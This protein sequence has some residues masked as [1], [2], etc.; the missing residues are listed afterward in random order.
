MPIPDNSKI[1][2]ND[3]KNF[4]FPPKPKEWIPKISFFSMDLEKN[5]AEY[6]PLELQG[7]KNILQ[8]KISN[9]YFFL[10]D[11]FG[12]NGVDHKGLIIPLFLDRE[13]RNGTFCSGNCPDPIPEE[14]QAIFIHNDFLKKGIIS[15]ELGHS[16][17]NSLSLIG[18]IRKNSVP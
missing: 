5:S 8:T 1:I 13:D 12:L 16:I 11:N 4:S 18:K 3:Y 14:L 6:F 2:L 7:K 10:R 15:H 17:I 9:F